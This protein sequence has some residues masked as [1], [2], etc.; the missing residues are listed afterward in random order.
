MLDNRVGV[1]PSS[2]SGLDGVSHSL[3]LSRL[4]L[5]L[6]LL[7]FLFVLLLL[8]LLLRLLL[9]L[10]LFLRWELLREAG[11][12]RVRWWREEWC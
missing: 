3:L 4:L 2:Q 6:L 1:W 7:F 9:P 8:L 12:P 5:L 11:C 10:R